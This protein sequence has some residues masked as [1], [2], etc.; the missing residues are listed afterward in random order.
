MPLLKK[1]IYNLSPSPK[2]LKESEE[3]FV[4]PE[5][6]ECFRSYD[7]YIAKVFLYSSQHWSCQYTSRSGL[8]FNDALLSEKEAL[9][10]LE[11]FPD[12]FK[13]EVLK[14]VHKS[15]GKVKDLVDKCVKFLTTHYSIQEEVVLLNP[16]NGKKCPGVIIEVLNSNIKAESEKENKGIYGAAEKVSDWKYKVQLQGKDTVLTDISPDEIKHKTKLPSKELLRLFIKYSS[17]RYSVEGKD[18]WLV[19]DD[20]VQKYD[21]PSAS[22]L[23]S[24]LKGQKKAMRNPLDTISGQNGNNAP[25]QKIKKDP[26]QRTLNFFVQT[27]KVSGANHSQ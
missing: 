21:L 5:T 10:H 13:E 23:K 20:L 2:D 19:K 1:K 9:K 16:K 25:K 24:G 17:E 12:C 6:K 4:I 22:T 18:M 11:K 8:T 27:P 7:E 3:L 14:C 15:Q 26:S